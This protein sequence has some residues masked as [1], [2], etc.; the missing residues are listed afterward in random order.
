MQVWAGMER[1]FSSG[2]CLS[3]TRTISVS[4]AGQGWEGIGWSLP[5]VVCFLVQAEME[6]KIN[7][8]GLQ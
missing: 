3:R 2:V 7:I 5:S 1:A 4:E 6:K 8:K